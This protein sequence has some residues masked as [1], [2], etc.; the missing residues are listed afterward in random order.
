M[1]AQRLGAAVWAACALLAAIPVSAAPAPGV[2]ALKD[3]SIEDLSN[4]EINSVSKRDEKLSDAPTSVF[5]ITSEDIRRS[6]ATSL[7]EALRLAPNLQVARVSGN[8]Y[9]ISA[10]GFNGT[11]ANKL[12]VLIDGRSVYSP[13]FSGVFWDVQ[14][15]MIEDIERIEVISGSGGTLWGVN[16]VNGVINV[17]TRTANQ[18]QG[19]LAI[20]GGGNREDRASLRYGGKFGDDVSFRIYA[21]HFDTQDTETQAGLTKDDAAHQSQVGFRADWQHEADSFMVKG[22][23]YNGREGQP[24]PGSISITGDTLALGEISLSG[25]N[26]ISRW[27]HAWEGS[28]ALSV[29]AYYDHTERSVPPTFEDSQGIADLQLQ[30]SANPI[31]GNT[32]VVGAEYRYGM[33]RVTNSSYIALFPPDLTQA[34]ASLFAQDEIA[35]RD[36]LRLTL[37]VRTEHNDY[38]GTQTLPTARLAWKPSANEMLWAAA[39]RTDRAPSRLDHDIF[40]PGQAPFLLRGGPDVLAET[41]TDYEVGYRGQIGSAA[42]LSATVYHTIYDR[43][44][45]QQIDPTFTYIFYGNGMQGTTSGLELWGSYQATPIWRLNAGFS[46]LRQE[47]NLT[48][49]SIDVGTLQSTEGANPTRWGILRST[50]D[51]GPR[52]EF[53]LT[54]RYVGPLSQPVVSSYTAL[55][56]RVGWQLRS[57]LDLSLLGQNLLGGGHGEFT[58]VAT[59]TD[60]KRAVFLK[61]VCRL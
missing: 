12:L 1:R 19:G 41:A 21:T 55:D 30:Y 35:L 61:L 15:V 33:D 57:N 52:T 4:I 28:G 50:L 6:G 25:A 56:L 49:Y 37:G 13:L 24:P 43:L 34:W 39:S 26:I 42:S 38:T 2:Q 51:L 31:G 53:D 7:P 18:T 14:D 29:Q 11:A 36:S 46:R 8:E 27:E 40:V 47:F 10:R 54:L 20:A 45:T 23:A 44:R 59:R 5:V 48:P 58:D 3:L 17:I 32:V 22:D 9:A 60:F 16:A